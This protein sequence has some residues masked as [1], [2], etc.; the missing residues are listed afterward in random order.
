MS[1]SQEH[2]NHAEERLLVEERNFQDGTRRGNTTR[3]RTSRRS[4]QNEA[5]N[6]STWMK[7]LQCRRPNREKK[8]KIK[9]AYELNKDLYDCYIEADWDRLG[10]TEC[11]KNLWDRIHPD[12]DVSLKYLRTQVARIISK[13]LIKETQDNQQNNASTN[14]PQPMVV[15]DA[16]SGFGNVTQVEDDSTEL[17]VNTEPSALTDSNKIDQEEDN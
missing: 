11:M 13:K 15:T 9:W 16:P 5:C 8:K 6:T 14:A 3:R 12:P 4:N 10:Y 2:Q 17:E 1:E 7:A